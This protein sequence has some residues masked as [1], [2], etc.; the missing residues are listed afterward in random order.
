MRFAV[1][2]PVLLAIERL[3]RQGHQAYLVGG[4][5]R[6]DLLGIPPKD[7]DI[8]TSARPEEIIA[9]FKG[10]QL[11]LNGLKHGTVT[12][13][14]NGVPLEITSFRRDG[15]SPSIRWPGA[16]KQALWI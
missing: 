4:C 6:D 9:C 3:N 13:V 15:I 5:V 2:A 10:E 12:P 7:H 16:R 8:A 11:L 1:P 14:L